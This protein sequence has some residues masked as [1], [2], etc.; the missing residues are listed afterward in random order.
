MLGVLSLRNLQIRKQIS[1]PYKSV[2]LLAL[3][4][5]S[6]AYYR[7][8]SLMGVQY[9]YTRYFN[10][11]RRH[12]L[13]SGCIIT[14]IIIIKITWH[15]EIG[16]WTPYKPKRSHVSRQAIKQQ[17]ATEINRKIKTEKN[18]EGISS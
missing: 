7:A 18:S 9:L 11:I 12:V 3:S 16:K 6:S 14:I 10:G 1:R 13:L 2:D 5:I 4:R 8:V 15:I 17:K